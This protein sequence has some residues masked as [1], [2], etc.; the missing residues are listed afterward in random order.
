MIFFG[1]RSSSTKKDESKRYNCTHCSSTNTVK[2]AKNFS[3]LHIFWIPVFP[4][5]SKI[6]TECSHCK[7]VRFQKEIDKTT[8]RNIKSTLN[9]KIPFQYYTGL[10]LIGLFFTVLFSS[11][12]F[13]ISQ[14]NKGIST[15]EVGDIYKMKYTDDGVKQYTIYRIRNVENDSITFEMSDYSVDKIREL[16]NLIKNKNATYSQTLK[17]HRNELKKMKYNVIGIIKKK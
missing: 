1:T 11:V 10:I 5:S 12:A 16:K 14:T 8:V 15:P 2:V 17:K 4:Y 13:S 6:I 7:N 3:Y 9:V